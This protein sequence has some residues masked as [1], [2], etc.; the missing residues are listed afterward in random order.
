MA[1]I[2]NEGRLLWILQSLL[3]FLVERDERDLSIRQ[4]SVFL[5]CYQCDAPQ[6]VRGLAAQLNIPKAS[7]TRALD[8]LEQLQLAYR[9]VEPSDRRSVTVQRT[10]AGTALMRKIEAML[11]DLAAGE[12]TALER[13]AGVTR[14]AA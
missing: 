1:A 5:I 10:T 8:R 14:R 3:T 9:E 7:V 13:M 11:S 12:L 6:T 4:L 2:R